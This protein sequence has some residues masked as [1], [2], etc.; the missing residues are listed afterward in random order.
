MK[1][2]ARPFRFRACVLLEWYP[3]VNM[4]ETPYSRN[5]GASIYLW[6]ATN[7]AIPPYFDPLGRTCTVSADDALSER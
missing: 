2:V 7:R 5:R 4:L 6:A 1:P 3:H